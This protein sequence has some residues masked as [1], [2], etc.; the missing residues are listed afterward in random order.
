MAKFRFQDLKIWHLAIQ[1]A[2]E[3]F[4]IADELEM[5]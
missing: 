1:I 2:D 4:R 3:L 5:K